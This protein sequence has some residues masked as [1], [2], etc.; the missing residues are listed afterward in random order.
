MAQMTP[1]DIARAAE[2]R[3]RQRLGVYGPAVEDV[4]RIHHRLM[5]MLRVPEQT[6]AM[7]TLA[8]VLAVDPEE[9]L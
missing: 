7:L 9:E 5:D 4:A 1:A 2:N 3:V 6:A 8:V